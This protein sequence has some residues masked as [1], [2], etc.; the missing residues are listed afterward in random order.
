MEIE[1]ME[2]INEERET[3]EWREM[4]SWHLIDFERGKYKRVLFLR[5]RWCVEVFPISN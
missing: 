4:K 3:N 2:G 5:V 1:F